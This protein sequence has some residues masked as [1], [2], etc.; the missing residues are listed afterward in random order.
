MAR[1][2]FSCLIKNLS[3]FPSVYNFYKPDSGAWTD[4]TTLANALAVLRGR[5]DDDATSTDVWWVD[6]SLQDTSTTCVHCRWVDTKGLRLGVNRRF[7]GHVVVNFGGNVAEPQ[8]VV[9]ELCLWS[10]LRFHLKIDEFKSSPPYCSKTRKINKW[11][12]WHKINFPL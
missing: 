4:R 2:H 11:K 8:R 1:E 3:F 6:T 7:A 9:A 5:R 12:N 10:E